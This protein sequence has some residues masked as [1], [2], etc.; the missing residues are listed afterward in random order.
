MNHETQ[1]DAFIAYGRARERAA[2]AAT[3]G[4]GGRHLVLVAS[5]ETAPRQE[6]VAKGRQARRRRTYRRAA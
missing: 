1:S 3:T 5:E 2:K 6:G 4:C